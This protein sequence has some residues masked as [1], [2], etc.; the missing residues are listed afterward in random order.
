MP[1][2]FYKFNT[3]RKPP[4]SKANESLIVN[5]PALTAVAEN[6]HSK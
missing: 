2:V 1:L 4:F 3:G 6:T 5:V